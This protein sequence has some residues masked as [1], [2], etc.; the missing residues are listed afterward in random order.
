MLV[1]VAVVAP[2]IVA[3]ATPV[4]PD[5]AAI[6]SVAPFAESATVRYFDRAEAAPFQLVA[7]RAVFRSSVSPVVRML[8]LNVTDPLPAAGRM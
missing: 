5:V 7:A 1:R 3:I 8:L 4:P 6:D 2:L